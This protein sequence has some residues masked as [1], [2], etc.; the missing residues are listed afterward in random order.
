[1]QQVTRIG[2]RAEALWPLPSELPEGADLVF[3]DI[4]DTRSKH[5]EKLF[6]IGIK[7][8]PTLIGIAGYES[9]SILQK[10][11]DLHVDAVVTKPLQA[12]GVLSSIVMARQI[13]KEFRRFERM[14][15]KLK[16]KV[17]NSQKIGQ[18]KFILMRLH[19]ISE[20]KAYEA[21]RSQAMSKRTTTVAIARAIINAD[22]ILETTSKKDENDEPAMRQFSPL[23]V[24]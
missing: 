15:G 13:W 5:L 19:Q 17:E 12:S 3:V 20:E 9:P 2:C 22:G 4:T 23:S 24:R 11:L 1:M 18:A 7:T 21:I 10:L 14:V 6:G 16:V 8:R